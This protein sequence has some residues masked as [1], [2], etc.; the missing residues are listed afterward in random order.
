VTLLYWTLKSKLGYDTAIRWTWVTGANNNIAFKIAAKPLQIETWLLLTAYRTSLPFY[1]TVPSPTLTA[2]RLPTIRALRT[3]RR[4]TNNITNV[5]LFIRHY[6]DVVER[7]VTCSAHPLVYTHISWLQQLPPPVDIRVNILCNNTAD[8]GAEV[9]AEQAAG[10][11]SA[12][13]SRLSSYRIHNSTHTSTFI[14]NCTTTARYQP[15]RTIYF[16]N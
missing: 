3:D 16:W 6:I 5:L 13:S 15:C 1:P 8:S 11:N 9:T 7:S 12:F 2:Y 4:Q 14:I 10:R